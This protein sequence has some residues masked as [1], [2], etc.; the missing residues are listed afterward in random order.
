MRLKTNSKVLHL[1]K[2]S[3][4]CRA[5]TF[6]QISIQMLNYSKIIALHFSLLTS[7]NTSLGN[8]TILKNIAELTLRTYNTTSLY[9][10]AKN[11]D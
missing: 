11:N 1:V 3:P 6:K 8:L 9:S 10:S 7:N 2:F 4:H 5:R